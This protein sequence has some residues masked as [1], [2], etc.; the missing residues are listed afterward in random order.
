MRNGDCTVP[1]WV[2][3]SER[4][5]AQ[6]IYPLLGSVHA[7]SMAGM[8][9][10]AGRA[11]VSAHAVPLFAANRRRHWKFHFNFII[12]RG[13]RN[14]M[15]YDH[16]NKVH[17]EKHFSFIVCSGPNQTHVSLSL[18]SSHTIRSPSLSRWP[19]RTEPTDEPAGFLRRKF[20]SKFPFILAAGDTKKKRNLKCHLRKLS[21]TFV[22]LLFRTPTRRPECE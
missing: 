10:C 21:A 19:I 12:Q 6:T 4:G 7:A 15:F 8:H 18:S 9:A 17:L 20:I 5:V 14:K 16:F 22:D 13:Y 11:C 3:V 1:C 2:W